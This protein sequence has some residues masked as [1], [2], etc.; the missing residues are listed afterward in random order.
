MRTYADFWTEYFSA[1]VR[2]ENGTLNINLEN[3]TWPGNVPFYC[4]TSGTTA[5]TKF[6]PFSW[7][8]FAEN[9]RAALDLMACY[10]AGNGPANYSE[11]NSSTCRVT[12]S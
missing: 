6:I 4:E 7:E 2:D 3:V 11:G 9:R 8:M 1:G 10:L 12:P 5:P